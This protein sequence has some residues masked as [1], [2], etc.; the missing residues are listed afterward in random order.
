MATVTINDGPAQQ[1]IADAVKQCSVTDSRGRVI[2]LQRP[3][4]LAQFRI[5]EVVGKDSVEN[6]V[7]MNMVLPLIY[8]TSIAGESITLPRN[9]LQLEALVQLLDEDGIEAVGEG[10][11]A[12]WGEQD[13]EKEKADVKK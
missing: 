6:R 8:V 2:T 1:V 13:P 7:Y 10:V 12:N 4:I 3:G 5:V 9:K 11:M